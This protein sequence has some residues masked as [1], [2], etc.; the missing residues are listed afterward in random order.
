MIIFKNTISLM[1]GS[2]LS[3]T[4]FHIIFNLLFSGD[5][6]FK[7]IK[8]KPFKICIILSFISFIGALVISFTNIERSIVSAFVGGISCFLVPFQKRNSSS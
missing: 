7:K 8:L 5:L 6:I 1:F 3:F 4:V 2:I